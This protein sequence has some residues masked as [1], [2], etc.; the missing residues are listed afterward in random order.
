MQSQFGY[1][2]PTASQPLPPVQGPAGR[3][4]FN[5]TLSNLLAPGYSGAAA[6][7]GPA[8]YQS[9]P[10]TTATVQQTAVKPAVSSRDVSTGLLS[11]ISAAS[12]IAPGN[13]AA[14]TATSAA[15]AGL[16]AGGTAFVASGFNP[17]VGLVAGGGATLASLVNSWMTTKAERKRDRDRRR[18]L[19]EAARKQAER[20]R[21]ARRDAVEQEGYNRQQNAVRTAWEK[22]KGIMDNMNAMISTNAAL[23]DRFVKLGRV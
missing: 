22:N 19:D 13:D 18:L 10:P 6:Y 1:L 9:A 7:E 4:P 21:I 11:G 3:E 8:S 23:K 16:T 15:A 5:P 12:Q 2:P 14:S 17:V 20:D